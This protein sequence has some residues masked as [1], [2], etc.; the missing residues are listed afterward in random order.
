[1]IIM[2]RPR[3]LLTCSLLVALMVLSALPALA[4]SSW[5]V[6]KKSTAL[7]DAILFYEDSGGG[8]I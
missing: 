8:S 6:V 4:A 1:M 2:K 7:N 5:Y 3:K